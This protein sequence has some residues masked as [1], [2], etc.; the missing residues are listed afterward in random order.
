[1]NTK[2]YRNFILKRKNGLD[3]YDIFQQENSQYCRLYSDKKPN[4]LYNDFWYVIENEKNMKSYDLDELVTFST[5][6]ED[7]EQKLLQYNRKNVVFDKRLH[8]NDII[9]KSEKYYNNILK[10]N[11]YYVQTSKNPF[12]R[13]ISEKVFWNVIVYEWG[14]GI[15]KNFSDYGIEFNDINIVYNILKEELFQKIKK[16]AYNIEDKK[17]YKLVNYI[18]FLGEETYNQLNKFPIKMILNKKDWYDDKGI[19]QQLNNPF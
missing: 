1:M 8:S 16:Y 15:S 2:N 4:T 3:F 13:I 7:L 17:L 12:K 19:L 10:D 18:M 5:I 14:V 11:T 6:W 9:A